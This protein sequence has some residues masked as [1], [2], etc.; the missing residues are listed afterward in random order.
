MSTNILASRHELRPEPSM[1][2]STGEIESQRRESGEHRFDESFTPRSVLRGGPV[3]AM[4]QLRSCDCGD[5]NLFAG[6]ELA[7]EPSAHL[8]HG[9]TMRAASKRPLEV[10]EDGR[11]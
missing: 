8:G 5:P 4:E 3:H 1:R 7:L 10:D 2:A 11:V 9:T 6:S